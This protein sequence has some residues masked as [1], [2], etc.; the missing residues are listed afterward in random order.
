MAFPFFLVFP[1][2]SVGGPT[3]SSGFAQCGN[4]GLM[5]RVFA[6]GFPFAP[7]ESGMFVLLSPFFFFHFL[8]WSQTGAF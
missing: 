6:L 7:L 4:A 8:R 1:E 3:A 2:I 5:E